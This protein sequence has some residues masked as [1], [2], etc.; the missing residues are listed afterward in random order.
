MPDTETQTVLLPAVTGTK[1]RQ[2]EQALGALAEGKTWKE[3]QDLSNL[4]R[5]TV[6]R[7]ATDHEDWIT[8]KQQEWQRTFCEPFE[9]A[10]GKRLEDACIVDSRTGAQSYKAVAETVFGL[11]GKGGVNVHIGD[12]VNTVVLE[13]PSGATFDASKYAELRD[14]LGV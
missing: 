10:T 4:S 3:A 1:V 14:R 12:N 5:A 11:G 13:Q 8:E 7:V 6:A 9:T 2:K